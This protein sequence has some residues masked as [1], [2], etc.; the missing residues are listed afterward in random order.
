MAVLILRNIKISA[1]DRDYVV[2]FSNNL[3]NL[4]DKINKLSDENSFFIID[5]KFNEN[6]SIDKYIGNKKKTYY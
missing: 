4:V 6:Y 1:S 3:M 2:E 5:Q